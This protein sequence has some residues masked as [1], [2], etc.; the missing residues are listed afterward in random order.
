MAG[1]VD[2]GPAAH[3]EVLVRKQLSPDGSH[4]IFGSTNRS[5]PTP[6]RAASRRSTCATS[7]PGPPLSSRRR[8][9]ARTFLAPAPA[10][11][12]GSPGLD[13]SADGSHVVVGQ[14]VGDGPSGA[15]LWHLYTNVDGSSSS[16]DLTPGS[17]D[18]VFY[19]GMTEDGSKAFFSSD[20]QFTL[21]D[22]D[23]SVDLYKSEIGPGRCAATLIRRAQ[24]K[25]QPR[26]L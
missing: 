21:D 24:R 3:A 10:R 22:E 13:V 5:R 8:T 16:I 25:R 26:F 17:T 18:G 6:R 4:L 20:Q 15:S 7:R 11:P 19:Y 1:S 2:P 14:L 9:P 12:K 23:S